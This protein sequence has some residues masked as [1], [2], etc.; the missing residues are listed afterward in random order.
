MR[1]TLVAW[2]DIVVEGLLL[3][4]MMVLIGLILDKI[5]INLVV[6]CRRLL[7]GTMTMNN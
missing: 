5:S 3:L 2:H 4:V 7:I 1:V 6:I